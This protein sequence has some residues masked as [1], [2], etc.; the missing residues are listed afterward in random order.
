MHRIARESRRMRVR[1]ERIKQR[2][3]ISA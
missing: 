3:L 1:P 2:A